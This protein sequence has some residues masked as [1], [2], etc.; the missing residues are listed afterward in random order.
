MA[1]LSDLG[2]V[3]PAHTYPTP[4]EAAA[5]PALFRNDVETQLIALVRASSDDENGALLRFVQRVAADWDSFTDA[6]TEFLQTGGYDEA[7]ARKMAE[8]ILAKNRGGAA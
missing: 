1:N 3:P 4:E 5:N 2:L 7:E 8:D 6:A